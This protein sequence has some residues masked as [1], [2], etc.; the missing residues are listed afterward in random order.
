[1]KFNA[2]VLIAVTLLLA[3]TVLLVFSIV[4]T[5]SI[6][7]TEKWISRIAV[8]EEPVS[9][10]VS[11][12]EVLLAT[13]KPGG[14]Q[15]FVIYRIGTD[16]NVVWRTTGGTL[17]GR[18]I[19]PISISR[20]GDEIIVISLIDTRDKIRIYYYTTSGL[21]SKKVD[22]NLGP[23]TLVFDAELYS[24]GSILFGGLKYVLG[25]KAQYYIERF[26]PEDNTRYWSISWGTEGYDY[27]IKLLVSSNGYVFALGNST[28]QGYTLTCIDGDGE[29]LWSIP[30]GK[31]EPVSL[32]LSP[33]NNNIYLLLGRGNKYR[34]L[35]IS[36]IDGGLVNS[37]ELDL[38]PLFKYATLTDFEVLA[39]NRGE[40]F[41]IT[42][43]GYSAESEHQTLAFILLYKPGTGFEK[44]IKI[45][46]EQDTAIYAV[47]SIDKSLYIVGL[48]GITTFIGSYEVGEGGID[49]LAI[50]TS[51]TT[52][53]ISLYI[54]FRE[55]SRKREKIST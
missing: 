40:V 26:N 32:R 9:V 25:E 19:Y 29:I 45:S 5:S 3:S 37:Y 27:I 42:G 38:S 52:A 6:E 54:L 14:Y 49:A 31:S 36:S 39:L 46:S 28:L 55:V 44:I 22:L 4:E 50:I 8:G 2:V 41:A 30:L 10:T 13:I 1:M 48:A 35:V 34:V 21:L 33:D 47:T 15:S 17:E 51:L 20:R 53:S 12:D 23:L 43:T 7:V 16:G 24:D 18:A 11:D